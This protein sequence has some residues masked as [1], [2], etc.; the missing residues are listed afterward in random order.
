LGELSHATGDAEMALMYR[1]LNITALLETG[2]IP[3]ADR[4]IRAYTRLSETLQLP[5]SE[6]YVSLFGAMRAL[7]KGRYSDA[8]SSAQHFLE[9]GN[10]VQDQNAPQ[11][12]GAHLFLRLWEDNRLT[13]VST[14]LEEFIA[15][16]PMIPAWKSAALFIHSE[17][18]DVEA[19]R[20]FD[21]FAE[22]GFDNLPLNE[23]WAV[24]MQM[25]SSACVNIG[26]H[27]SALQLYQLSLPGKM[28]HT[29]VGYGVMSF[30][31]RAREL[32][33]L[34]SLM[35]R[36]EEAEEHFELAISQNRK[37]GAAPWVARSQ[38]DYAQMLARQ[39]DPAVKDRIRELIADAQQAADRLGMVRLKLQVADLVKEL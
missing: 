30:G 25:L 3:A 26:D 35:G 32:G 19:I 37:T 12:F 20:L 24:A 15:Q 28:H 8:A 38:F 1:I 10:R 36:F 39:R 33:N 9:I 7:M 23:T 14:L 22:F 11:S 27:S 34:A 5:H 2:D 21:E 4:E 29:I 17:T 18:K 16:H 31:S 13:E 6:W